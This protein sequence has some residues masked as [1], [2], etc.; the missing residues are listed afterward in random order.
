MP[1]AASVVAKYLA[2]LEQLIAEGQAIP[3]RDVQVVSGGNF[4]TKET[5]Y[6]QRKQ[7]GWAEFVE[8]R[9][10]CATLLD[11]VV[12]QWSIHRTTVNGFGNLEATQSTVQGGTSF[13][14]AI[15]DDLRDG[16]FERLTAE[17]ESAIVADYVTQ[18]EQL[19][20][21]DTSER[22]GYVGIAVLAGSIL[23]GHLR[24]MCAQLSPAEPIAAPQS[25]GALIEVFKRRGVIAEPRAKQLR[26][27]A[28]V[29]NRAAHGKF[30]EF[31]K[32]DVRLM[33][34]GIKH[35]LGEHS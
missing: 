33:V 14:K 8:W 15:H 3:I 31:S 4:L 7:V 35:F 32:E 2:R 26:A 17:I 23:E 34:S 19:L 24:T 22:A 5:H 27:W 29:R 16:F 10:K 1:L 28:D 18:I 25:L 30:D 20:A 12:P 11:Q 6:K 21:D 9:T 13:L